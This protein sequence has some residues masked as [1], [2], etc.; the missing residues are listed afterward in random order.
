MTRFTFLCQNPISAFYQDE[1]TKLAEIAA[2]AFSCTDDKLAKFLK[3]Y[4]GVSLLSEQ[5]EKEPA[6]NPGQHG[7][8]PEQ[9]PVINGGLTAGGMSGVR[10]RRQ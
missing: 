3:G 10:I 4:P 1:G 6:F 2:G 8:V 5:P 9:P 7:P